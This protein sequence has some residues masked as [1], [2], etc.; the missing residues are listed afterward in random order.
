MNFDASF[1]TRLKQRDPAACTYL[2]SSLTP[3]LEARLRYKLRDHSAIEDIRNETFYRVFCMV[4]G[5]RVREPEQ[6]GSFVRGVCDRVAQESRR[7]AH[8]TEPFPGAGMEPTDCQPHLDKLLVDK[9]RSALV[10]REVM[11]L[12]EADRRLI[13]ELYCQERD[14]REMARE[15]GISPTGLNVRLCR[16]LKRLRMELLQ[17]EPAVQPACRPRSSGARSALETHAYRP[18]NRWATMA[19]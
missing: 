11:K 13:V 6:L 12:S 10:W 17:P 19:A 1:L 9:E 2:V 5:G 14:R 8:A 15:R 18:A 7:K 16:A 4:D 3:V